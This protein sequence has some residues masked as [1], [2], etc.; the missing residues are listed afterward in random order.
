MKVVVTFIDESNNIVGYIQSDYVEMYDDH[1]QREYF[2]VDRRQLLV[3]RYDFV[4]NETAK[5]ATIVYKP[6]SS[7]SEK[8]QSKN[9]IYFC[10]DVIL[11]DITS[12]EQFEQ[13]MQQYVSFE[14]FVLSNNHLVTESQPQPDS[15]HHSLRRDAV[16]SAC[17]A[18]RTD[19]VIDQ[20]RQELLAGHHSNSCESTVCAHEPLESESQRMLANDECDDWVIV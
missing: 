3:E 18:A 4:F 6:N 9:N 20:H 11:S 13:R 16:S 5:T 2:S 17:C 1:H 7:Y 8:P 15:S 19:A 14:L 12:F 10:Q